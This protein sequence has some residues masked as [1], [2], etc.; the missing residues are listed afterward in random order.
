MDDDIKKILVNAGMKEKN[1][2]FLLK[3]A[4]KKN[5]SVS[6][7]F[8]LYAWKYYA[9]GGALFFSML[10][11]ATMGGF[12]LFIIYILCCLALA[13]ISVFFNPFFINLVWSIKV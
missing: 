11:P 9:W 7:A 8:L 12:E 2:R 5:I 6:R 3:L 10:F 13:L 4:A 1:V